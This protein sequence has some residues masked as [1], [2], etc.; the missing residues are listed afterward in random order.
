ME[1]IGCLAA[2]CGFEAC[3]VAAVEPLV[4]DK[5]I[6]QQ[7]LDAGKHGSMR[8]M[9]NNVDLRTDPR[10][11][12]DDARS[13]VVV[14]ANYYPARRQPEGQ[15][16]IAS[17]A[18]GADYHY[19]VR[20]RLAALAEEID[21]V[22]THRWAVFTD[23]AP[24]F[25]RAWAVRAG[26]GWIG[27]S[28]MLVNPRLGTYTLIGIMFTTLRLPASKPVAPRCGTCRRCIGVCPT[29][30]ISATDTID[31][32]RCLSYLTI[33]NREPV[34]DEFLD[35]AADTL[36]GCDRCMAVCP[37][38]RFA[39]PTGIGEFDPIGGLFDVD[40]A[41]IGRGEF[42]RLLR[43]S[44]MQRAGHRKLR[45]RAIQIEQYCRKSHNV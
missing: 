12:L 28:G 5:A 19:V 22:S 24:V 21:A 39:H 45:Q 8:Y 44:A 41:G 23:S 36:Y 27:K 38:N 31:A 13:A 32:R 43:N 40:W 9:A 35:A 4:G 11:L 20:Q 15:P 34:P 25:E 14:L 2:E 26:L 6:L 3:G 10:L 16:R 29:G 30:A 17:Y 7:W 18:Y 37:W 33:E 1:E 42:N